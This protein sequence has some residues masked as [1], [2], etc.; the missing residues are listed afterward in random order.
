VPSYVQKYI[1]TAEIIR[2]GR[3]TGYGDNW[4]FIIPGWDLQYKFFNVGSLG[5]AT[6]C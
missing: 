1:D 2:D 6:G 3:K 4:H 5:A